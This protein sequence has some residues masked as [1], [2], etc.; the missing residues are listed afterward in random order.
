MTFQR[1]PL[2]GRIPSLDGI[3]AISITLVLF[4]HASGPGM[5]SHKRLGDL[6][7][8][9]GVRTFF[10]LS[11]L[12]ITTLLVREQH[13]SLREFYIRRTLRI[14]PAFYAYA[15]VI[16]LLATLGVIALPPDDFAALEARSAGRAS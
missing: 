9:F 15:I 14:F 16:A 2:Q 5:P 12:L 3:R 11:G 4:A 13:V 10:V 1:W 8:D 6:A 7:G